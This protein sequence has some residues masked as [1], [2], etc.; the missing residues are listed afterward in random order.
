MYKFKGICLLLILFNSSI[1]FDPNTAFNEFK[2]AATHVDLSSLETKDDD[3]R[4]YAVRHIDQLFPD[5]ATK[6]YRRKFHDLLSKIYCK[7]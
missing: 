1:A 6:V 2:E 4:L 5:G 3:A 7:V